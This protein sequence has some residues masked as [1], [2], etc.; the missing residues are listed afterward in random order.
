MLVLGTAQDGGL[1]QIGCLLPCCERGR[2][3]PGARRLVTSLLLADPRSGRRWLFD[4]TP[5]LAEQ[6]ERARDHP[7][8]RSRL[9][10]A[11]G[12]G[13]PPLFEGVFLTHAHMGHVAGLLQFGREAYATRDMPAYVSAEM[14]GFLSHNGPW[15][16][17]VDGGHLRLEQMASGH[18]RQLAEDLSVTALSVP[19]RPEFSDTLAFLVRGPRRAVLYLPD[20]DKWERW[21][22]SIESVLEQV[23]V[24]LLDGSFYADG[25]IPDRSMADIPHPFMV[26]SLRRFAG[27]P[28]SERA[29]VVFTHLN[30]TNPAADAH[31][32]A[33]RAVRQAGMSIARD[34]LVIEL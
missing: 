13:R 12:G 17:L 30:H 34:G 20:I 16:L 4:A 10:G 29:K 32:A 21:D 14:A 31:S 25:E 18:T 5:D 11:P 28:A 7:P 2:E 33:A 27:L 9:T 19:H 6:V 22:T 3:Q 24:A 23:D 26:E 1:P 15:S 8:D